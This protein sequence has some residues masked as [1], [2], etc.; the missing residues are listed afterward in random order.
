[1]RAT[2]A[3]ARDREGHS[4]V[5]RPDGFRAT[6]EHVN[7]APAVAPDI[8]SQAAGAK[9]SLD[10]MAR[11]NQLERQW[12]LLQLIDRPAGVTVEDAAGALGCHVRTIWRDVDVLARAGLP[13]Y[14]DQAGDGQRTVWRVTDDFRRRLPLKLGL[15]E[16]LALLMS[17]DLL[18]AA[19]AS[20]L[21]PDLASALDKIRGLLSP[22][23]L[24]LLDAMRETVGVRAA[25]AKLQAPAPELLARIHQ[26]M[27]AG[28][29]LRIRHYSMER[30][31]VTPRTV[32]PYHLTS[33]NG[34]LYLI[35][36]CHLRGAVRLFAL[37]RIRE[38][39]P[40]AD[41]FEKPADFDP[42]EYL[43]EAW[44]I[45]RGTLV[46]VRVA[47]AKAAA[48]Y[49]RERLW[50]S[51]QKLRDL[52]DGRLELTLQ[53]ADTHEVRRWILGWGAQAE[54]VQP[55]AMREALRGEAMA[56]VERM[57]RRGPG[58]A[59]VDAG[60]TA[61]S[62]ARSRVSIARGPDDRR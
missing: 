55:T 48:P 47:F 13:I 20:A 61:A 8:D 59:R 29:A 62:H 4:P 52:P 43:K 31:E 50:H 49:I 60:A 58:L 25:G 45:V 40:T 14:D 51:T 9:E 6:A 27:L 28:H 37:E 33:F 38:A 5:E 24:R 30:D 36:H 57:G 22:D 19:G 39:A 3:D 12:R 10:F 46:T 35:A 56:M 44:G 23:A 11:G 2:L 32:D 18:A 16:L 17:R 53:V 21:G 42:D 41:R 26:A 34:G 15:A 1:M 7:S 54:V